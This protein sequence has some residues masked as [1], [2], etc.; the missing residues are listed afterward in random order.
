M[1]TRKYYLNNKKW[2]NHPTQK[3]VALCEYL[4]DTYTYEWDNC[5]DPTSWSW[6]FLKACKNKNRNWI[7]FELEEKRFNIANNNI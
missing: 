2:E 1:L 4:L 6:A 5:L 3:P 7:G